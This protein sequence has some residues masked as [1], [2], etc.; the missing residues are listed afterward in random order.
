MLKVDD[1]ERRWMPA[2][3]Q[4]RSVCESV[5]FSGTEH[6]ARDLDDMSYLQNDDQHAGWLVAQMPSARVSSSILCPRIV[7]V[8][9]NLVHIDETSDATIFHFGRERE[10]GRGKTEYKTS[11]KYVARRWGDACRLEI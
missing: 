2:M 10:K 3:F 4:C 8:S 11:E 1:V 7:A 9:Y 5:S 6:V